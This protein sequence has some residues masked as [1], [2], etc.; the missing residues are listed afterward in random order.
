M[1]WQLL[2]NQNILS[3]LEG[4]N[5]LEPMAIKYGRTNPCIDPEVIQ[6]IH[7]YPQESSITFCQ[8]L[9]AV[10]D[11]IFCHLSCTTNSQSTMWVHQCKNESDF[12]CL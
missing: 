5:N 10:Q 1:F 7:V 4:K 2:N 11:P 12:I 6:N 3:V 8:S 9:L